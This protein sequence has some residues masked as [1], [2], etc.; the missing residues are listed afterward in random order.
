M[1]EHEIEYVERKTGHCPGLGIFLIFSY[2]LQI[3]FLGT[4]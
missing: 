1:K 4:L 2:S 3:E